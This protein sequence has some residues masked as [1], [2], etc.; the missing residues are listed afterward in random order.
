MNDMAWRS[1]PRSAPSRRPSAAPQDGGPSRPPSAAPQDE[2]RGSLPER[3]GDDLA[4]AGASLVEHTFLAHPEVLARSTSLEGRAAADP[5]RPTLRRVADLA[6]AGLVSRSRLAQLET[7]ASRYAVAI[8]PAM[9]EL[10]DPADPADP[11]ARQFVPDEAELTTLPGENPDPIG[12]V[13]HSPVEG[14]VHRYPD[15]VLLKFVSVCAVYC[16]FCFRREMVGPQSTGTL[17]PA[18]LRAALDYIRRRREHLG[19][20]GERRRPAGRLAAP[21]RRH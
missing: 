14:L 2:D 8:T 15:R 13:P 5:G 12:D 9:V 6:D 17:S 4:V 1:A 19:S 7:V 16:R 11:I 3:A 20:R 21:T 10:I 18:S